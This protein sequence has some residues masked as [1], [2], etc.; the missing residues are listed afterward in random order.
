MQQNRRRPRARY[1]TQPHYPQTA[2]RLTQYR[3][4]LYGSSGQ[5]MSMQTWALAPSHLCPHTVIIHSPS[6][7][8]PHQTMMW[9]PEHVPL[10]RV[11]PQTA[12]LLSTCQLHPPS[13]TPTPMVQYPVHTPSHPLCLTHPPSLAILLHPHSLCCPNTITLLNDDVAP[14]VASPVPMC[15][16]SGRLAMPSHLDHTLPSPAM[17]MPATPHARTPTS[18][19][20]RDCT[21]TASVPIEPVPIDPTSV[22]PKTDPIAPVS[23]APPTVHG[24]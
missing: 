21:P 19:M 8:S 3:T 6:P 14:C 2:Q 18:G 12:P 9:H 17:P 15:L 4:C 5:Q 13:S 7:P 16:L 11:H 24:P 22:L 1:E 20:P 10:Q 23:T